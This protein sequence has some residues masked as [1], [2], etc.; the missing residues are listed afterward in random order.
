MWDKA[1]KQEFNLIVLYHSHR[2]SAFCTLPLAREFAPND[3][4]GDGENKLCK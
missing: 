4:G 2:H 1:D 3:A